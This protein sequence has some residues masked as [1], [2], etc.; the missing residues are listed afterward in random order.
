MCSL[1]FLHIF[2]VGNFIMNSLVDRC[3]VS[4]MMNFINASKS[5]LGINEVK[6]YYAFVGFK[7]KVYLNYIFFWVLTRRLNFF[8]AFVLFTW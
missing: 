7:I 4:L 6:H 1:K 8:T 3:S 2:I 5:A